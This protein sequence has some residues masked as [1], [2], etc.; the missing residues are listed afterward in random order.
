MPQS[1]DKA[2]LR[3]GRF[4]MKITLPLPNYTSRMKLFDYYLN[5]ITKVSPLVDREELAKLMNQKTGADIKNL[6]NQATM[7]SIMNWKDEVK[8]S[9]IE[10][11]FKSYILLLFC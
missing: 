11:I 5:K 1:L 6:I 2:L 3:P 9:G 10:Y 7:I 8:A 4:D